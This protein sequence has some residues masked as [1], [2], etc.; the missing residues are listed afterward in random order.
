MI[1]PYMAFGAS[2]DEV[3]KHMEMVHDDYKVEQTDSLVCYEEEGTTTY[4]R[5]YERGN[6][7]IRFG[8]DDAEGHQ[9]V[10]EALAGL[11]KGVGTG[12][13][14]HALVPGG[15]AHAKAA[16]DA[17]QQCGRPVLRLERGTPQQRL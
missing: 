8:F 15:E 16:A 6:R 3:E 17:G 7:Q 11:G 13:A 9:V 2:L 12:C 1:V 14:S 10:A 4:G 5:C